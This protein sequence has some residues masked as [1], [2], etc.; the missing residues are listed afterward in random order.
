[1]PSRITEWWGPHQGLIRQP[2]VH[3]CTWV[4]MCKAEDK[5]THEHA[6]E[7]RMQ[8]LV[9]QGCGRLLLDK[10]RKVTVLK[11]T[12]SLLIHRTQ[13]GGGSFSFQSACKHPASPAY[14]HS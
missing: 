2:R 6:S 5:A 10:H 3:P 13:T 4:H 11:P 7:C 12:A 9:R 14:S 1:M 8:S